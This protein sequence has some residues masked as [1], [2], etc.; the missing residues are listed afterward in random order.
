MQNIFT[1]FPQSFQRM[2]LDALLPPLCPSTGEP[3]S[4]PGAISARAFAALQFIDDP[5]CASC[6]APFAYE[7][8]EG[9]LCGACLADPPAFESAR[10]A[11]V[12]DDE[13]HGLVVAFKYS[14]RTDL[15]PLFARWMARAGGWL[16]TP[17]SLLAPVPLH[18]R[19]LFARRYNQAATLALALNRIA[20]GV[21]APMLLEKKRPTPPQKALSAEQRKRNVRG[22]FA[23][24]EGER[25]RLRGAHVV[26]IDDVMT[27]GATLSSAARTLR[28]AGAARVDAI[29]LARTGKSGAA[30]G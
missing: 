17:Q 23:V 24:R 22:V 9:A 19:R 30:I 3:V 8:G 18:W 21:F 13:S 26:L 16:I 4:E 14:D 27:T 15:A 1:K 5:V 7:V 6:G 12:Y 10:A 20:G 25:E 2:A 28:R 29:V 11:I